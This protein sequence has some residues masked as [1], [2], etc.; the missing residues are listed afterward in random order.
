MAMAATGSDH[1]APPYE[2]LAFEP[3]EE[4]MFDDAGDEEFPDMERNI[5]SLNAYN[6]SHGGPHDFDVLDGDRWVFEP[7]NRWPVPY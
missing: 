2:D 5:A 1:T 6:A 3:S 7:E 4:F